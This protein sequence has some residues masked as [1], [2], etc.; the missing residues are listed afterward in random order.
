[1]QQPDDKEHKESDLVEGAPGVLEPVV[2]RAGSRAGGSAASL[3]AGAA[4]SAAFQAHEGVA[5]DIAFAE[6]GMQRAIGVWAGSV[7]DGLAWHMLPQVVSRVVET[8]RNW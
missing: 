8:R 5:D 6:P 4:P 7:G 2:W 1:M 3:A